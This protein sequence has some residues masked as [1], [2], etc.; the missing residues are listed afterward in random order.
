MG[1]P[2]CC[3]AYH[4]KSRGEPERRR[5]LK[6]KK[7]SLSSGNYI[8]RRQRPPDP[9]QLELTHRLDFHGIFDLRQ[10]ARANENLPR[11]RFIAKPRGD[12]RDRADGGIVEASFNPI[13]PSVAKP[14]AMPMPNT[15]PNRR[16]AALNRAYLCSG[17]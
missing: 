14:C 6:W 5:L 3:L 1:A 15:L 12:V 8:V 11:L 17:R 13:V 9:L 4:K 2:L 16:Q 7:P 10:H